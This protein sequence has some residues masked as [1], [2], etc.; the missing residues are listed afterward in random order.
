MKAIMYHYVRPRDKDFP[1]L[2]RLDIESFIKQLD[3]FDDKYGFIEREEFIRAIREGSRCKGVILTFDDG[4]LC[5]YKHVFSELKKRKLWGIFYIPTAP[6]INKKILDVHRI[7][8]LLAKVDPKSIYSYL[9]QNEINDFLDDT[10][11]EE[12]KKLTY[13][14][15]INDQYTLNVKRILNY[16]ILYKHRSSVIDMVFKKFIDY[17]Y[18]V[19]DYYLNT[20][21]LKEMSSEGM[22]IGSHSENHMVMSKLSNNSQKKEIINSFDFLEN[23]LGSLSIKSFCYPYGGFHSFNNIT[24]NILEDQGCDFSFNVEQ[25]DIDINDINKRAQALP[26]YDC[27]QFPFGEATQH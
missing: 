16:F 22:M 21:N 26:R 5:H 24:E 18:T 27:N 10:K 6:F 15:Q 11:V 17:N 12:F 14:T 25:R 7:H 4:L 23:E 9:I 8:I 3:Y 13:Q 2:N 20:Q 1:N 19:D